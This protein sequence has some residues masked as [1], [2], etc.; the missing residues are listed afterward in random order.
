M[1]VLDADFERLALTVSD[2]FNHVAAKLEDDALPRFIAANPN[3]PPAR[4]KGTILQCSAAT[5]DV[6]GAEVF[7][8]FSLNF[9]ITFYLPKLFATAPY[10]YP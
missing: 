8:H 5:F 4:L 6:L 9:C 10:I 2:G 1:Q 7:R 3:T